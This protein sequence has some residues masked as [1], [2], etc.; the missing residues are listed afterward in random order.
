MSCSIFTTR[1]PCVLVV[2]H[3]LVIFNSAVFLL[4]HIDMYVQRW[5]FLVFL[6]VLALIGVFSAPTDFHGCVGWASVGFYAGADSRAMLGN[7]YLCF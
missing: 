7:I 6:H 4:L 3:L 5:Q 2:I 1:Q